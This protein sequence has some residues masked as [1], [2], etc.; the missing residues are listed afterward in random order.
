M[1]V[2]PLVARD[3][4]WN[5]CPRTVPISRTVIPAFRIATARSW[6]LACT[7]AASRAAGSAFCGYCVC[8][9][10]YLHQTFPNS[11]A[12]SSKNFVTVTSSISRFLPDKR[13]GV[14]GRFPQIQDRAAW[15]PLAI[16]IASRSTPAAC[17]RRAC[18]DILASWSRVA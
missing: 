2:S 16:C 1:D 9:G 12:Y 3:V 4:L 14:I 18:C 7:A 13:H 8:C 15:L 5:Q 11:W 10:H 6:V 17:S